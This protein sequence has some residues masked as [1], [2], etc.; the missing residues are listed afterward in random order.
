MVHRGPDD[1]GIVALESATLGHRRLAILDLS[2]RANQPMSSSDKR[3]YIT[4]NGEVYN[5]L[6][7]KKNLEAEGYKFRT[8]SDTEVVL[9]SFIHYGEQC[10]TKFN[11]MFAFAIWDTYQKSLFLA[12][13][14]FGKKPLYYYLDPSGA[15]CF[16]S[17]LTALIEDKTIPTKLSFEAIN[18]YLS[19]GYILSPLTIYESIFKLEPATYMYIS[20]NGKKVRKIKYWD[21][22]EAFRI[23]TNEKEIE[24]E[25]HV[26]SLLEEAARKRLISDVPVGAFLSGGIDSSSIVSLI[27]KYHKGDLHTFSVGFDSESYNELPDAQRTAEWIGTKHHNLICKISDGID[28]VNDAI[29]VFDEPFADNSLI[30]TIEVSKLASKYVT[31]VLSGDGADELFAGYITY[32]ADKYYKYFKIIPSIIKRSVLRLIKTDFSKDNVKL[33]WRYKQKQFLYGSLHSPEKAHYLWRLFFRPEERVSILGEQHRQLV[34]DTD[35]FYVFRKYYEKTRDFHIL[36]KN[37]YVDCMTWLPDDILV[38]LDRATMHSSIEG[39]CPYL[40][41]DLASYAA[42]I[43][44]ALKLKGLKTKYILKRSLSKVLPKFI[45]N[46]AKSGFNAPV[47]DWIGR[48]GADEF[49]K[50]NRYVYDRRVFGKSN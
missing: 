6:E 50:F 34:Y 31:V 33:S 19:L 42:A 44:P 5:F 12:R 21:F 39:R 10:L 14:R 8:T 38:K 27:K 48:N 24:I 36:D 25:K 28:F 32:K 40:D 11:G 2:S 1:N 20:E 29:S 43:P 18:C 30:P 26:L 23:K 41:I 46:K 37:L 17:E 3:Y 7:L 16:S 22:S 15:V 4:Y 45:L 47:G 49:K 35:P 9:Y 13:D